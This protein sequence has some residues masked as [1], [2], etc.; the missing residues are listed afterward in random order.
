VLQLKVFPDTGYHGKA[1]LSW[2]LGQPFWIAVVC[3]TVVAAFRSQCTYW[4]GRALRAGVLHG[5]WATRLN[6]PRL[7]TATERLERWGWPL[8]PLSFLT[9]GFQTAVHL[10]A[11]VVG[12]HWLRYT[13]AAAPGWLLWGFVYAAGGLA[14]FA[15]VLALAGRSPWLVAAVVVVL[16]AV[17]VAVVLRRRRARVVGVA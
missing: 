12:W 7:N 17:V 2:I 5:R 15:G 14:V 3:L 13:A 8:I 10:S 6:N 9:V 1:M 16:V 4:L 11:G